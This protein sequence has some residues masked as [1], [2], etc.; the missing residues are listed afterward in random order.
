MWIVAHIGLLHVKTAFSILRSQD[1]CGFL[2]ALEVIVIG[3]NALVFAQTQVNE[4]GKLSW[5]YSK[6]WYDRYV[7]SHILYRIIKPRATRRGKSNNYRDN[8]G[9][10]NYYSAS[11]FQTENQQSNQNVARIQSYR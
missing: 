3:I 7:L 2:G 6:T 8:N 11:N 10:Y 9:G 4:N 1:G 5:E